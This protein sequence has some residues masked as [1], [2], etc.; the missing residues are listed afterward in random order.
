MAKAAGISP[1]PSCSLSDNGRAD[2][3]ALMRKS[4]LPHVAN[5]E[6]DGRTL[7]MAFANRAGLR[8]DLEAFVDLERQCCGFLSFSVSSQENRLML[9]IEGPAG[10]ESTLHLF[11]DAARAGA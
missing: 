6:L 8:S 9:T 4:L 11:A 1:E 10:S 7:S 3:R 5:C 2:R